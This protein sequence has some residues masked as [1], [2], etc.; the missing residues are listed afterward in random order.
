MLPKPGG[1]VIK[2]DDWYCLFGLQ[3]QV[4]EGNCRDEKPMWA[5][6]GGLDF[7]G[8]ERW[9]KWSAA[10]GLD[11]EIAKLKWVQ[12]YGKAMAEERTALNFRKY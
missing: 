5:A 11:T 2:P 6:H 1:A 4:E 12:A 3:K 10:K 7:D 9:D 8:R